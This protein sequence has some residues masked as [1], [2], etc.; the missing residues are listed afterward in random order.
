L[1]VL[2]GRWLFLELEQAGDAI[3]EDFAYLSGR[4]KEQR[5]PIVDQVYLP[6]SENLVGLAFKGYGIVRRTRRGCRTGRG[7]TCC[8]DRMRSRGSRRRVMP[9][10]TTPGP[11][12]P[13]LT[14]SPASS[15]VYWW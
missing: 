15:E 14:V 8:R 1:E 7:L 11:N 5:T 13:A 3:S 9:I 4:D 10:W 12:E 2:P 6:V